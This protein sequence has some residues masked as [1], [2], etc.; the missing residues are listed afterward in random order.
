MSL[1][2]E[3]FVFDRIEVNFLIVGHTHSSIDQYFSVLSA[4]IH[5]TFFIGSPLALMNLLKQAHSSK[6]I[7]CR[8]TVCRQISVYYDVVQALKPFINKSI[9]VFLLTV[10]II[11]IIIIIYY[12]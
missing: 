6:K 1:L 5:S 11:I 9:K 7:E 2:I 3:S 10:L 8:P 4:R 12:F